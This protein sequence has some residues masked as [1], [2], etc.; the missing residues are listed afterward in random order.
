MV[1]SDTKG[2]SSPIRSVPET[3][4]PEATH[5]SQVP[6][7]GATG[8]ETA[9]LVSSLNYEPLE[10]SFVISTRP[11]KTEPAQREVSPLRVEGQAEEKGAA[12]RL[13]GQ[14]L[15]HPALAPKPGGGGAQS[16][17]RAHMDMGHQATKGPGFKQILEIITG[18]R[19][20]VPLSSTIRAECSQ[21]R[22]L[23]A[24]Q[25][26]CGWPSTSPPLLPDL[27]HPRPPHVPTAC[28]PAS[29]TRLPCALSPNDPIPPMTVLL[30][31][32]HP[33]FPRRERTSFSL[34]CP[35]GQSQW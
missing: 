4:T 30:S 7:M 31:H 9:C 21:R 14:N 6:R 10:L 27:L 26:P 8:E 2:F 16:K 17:V 23:E 28:A 13:G 29:G 18:C 3:H 33:K 35:S 22:E 15:A 1:H 19:A 20:E 24:A 5:R 25:A 11:Q 34:G 12:C 32:F